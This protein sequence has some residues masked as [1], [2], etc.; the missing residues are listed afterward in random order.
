MVDIIIGLG[1][2]VEGEWF[3]RVGS[4]GGKRRRR[5]PGI[6]LSQDWKPALK[7]YER[8]SKP[9]CLLRRGR[10]K[11]KRKKKKKMTQDIFERITLPPTIL[12]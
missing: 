10:R 3:E 6:L 4:L 7:K 11:R 5:A 8:I 1:L 12:E 2:V 9:I